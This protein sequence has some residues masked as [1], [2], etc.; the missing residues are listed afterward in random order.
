VQSFESAQRTIRDVAYYYTTGTSRSRAYTTLRTFAH[1]FVMLSR[2]RFPLRPSKLLTIR[3]D[4]LHLRETLF[5]RNS[6]AYG[7]YMSPLMVPQS[8]LNKESV[9]SMLFCFSWS[10]YTFRRAVFSVKVASAQPLPGVDPACSSAQYS[11]RCTYYCRTVHYSTVG[12][13]CTI[14]RWLEFSWY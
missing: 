9:V 7:Y 11:L 1:R 13:Y 5:G 2:G 12:T 4:A 8:L 14:S 3:C 6:L 10:W